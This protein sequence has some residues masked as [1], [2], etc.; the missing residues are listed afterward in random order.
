VR[1]EQYNQAIAYTSLI[2][3][4]HCDL[5]QRLPNFSSAAS[6]RCR[7]FNH[8]LWQRREDSLNRTTALASAAAVL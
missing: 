4:P 2:A 7:R 8:E 5:L 3:C 1:D 6:V